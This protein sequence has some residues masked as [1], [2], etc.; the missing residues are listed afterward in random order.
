MRL[1]KNSD[2]SKSVLSCNETQENSRSFE[3]LSRVSKNQ[4][5]QHDKNLIYHVNKSIEEKRLCILSDCVADI[6]IVVHEHEQ[7]HSNFEITFEI[8]SRSWYIRDLIKTLRAY[9]RNCSQCLQ[10]QI[11]R[12]KSWE[13]LQFIYSF[14]IFFHIITMNFVLELSKTKKKRNC[15]LSITNKFTKRILLISNKFTYMIEDWAIHL[16]KETQRRDWNISK[17]IIFDKNRKFLSDLWRTLF[18]KLSVF[19]F[20]STAYYS[21]IEDVSERINQTRKIALRYYIQELQNSTLWMI[22]LWKFQSVFNNTR[23][24]VIEKILNE[25]LYEVTSSLF[26]N[27]SSLNKTKKNHSQLKNKAEDAIN[28]A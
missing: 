21:Q 9:I 10:I 7:E 3:S 24:V 6:L 19:M 8:I 4:N 1:K 11:R 17:M 16:L 22:S 26:L 14:W 2:S 28:W 15:I 27:I 13:N 25:L 5:N 23:F 18:T 12:H 20:Y